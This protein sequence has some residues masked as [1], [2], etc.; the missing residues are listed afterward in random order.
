MAKRTL[1]DLIQVSLIDTKSNM[2]YFSYFLLRMR[3]VET[4][5]IETMGV[6]T[7]PTHITLYYNPEFVS[8]LSY[9]DF[10]YVLMHEILHITNFHQEREDKTLSHEI[11]NIAMDLAVNSILGIANAPK[12]VIC[13]GKG[14]F[15]DFP[16]NKSMEEY[17]ELLKKKASELKNKNGS[18]NGLEDESLKSHDNY[19]GH[20][21]RRKTGSKMSDE[22]KKMAEENVKN[23]MKKAYEYAKSKGDIPGWLEETILAQISKKINWK[24]YLRNWVGEVIQMGVEPSRRI[25]NKRYRQWHGIIPGLK[26]IYINPILIA[27]DTSGSMSQESLGRFIGEINNIQYPKTIIQCDAEITDVSVIPNKKLKE[28]KMKGRGGTDFRP[29]FKYA[30]EI[31]A[32]AL[33]FFTDLMGDFPEK[34]PKLKTLWITEEKEATAPFGEVVRML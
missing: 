15:K 29:V 1:S 10:K 32:K 22:E 23:Q 25:R 3:R 7:F 18:G 26:K 5:D 33:I 13:P 34:P 4:K 14:L 28:L 17:L 8:S 20:E 27:I 12:G 11:N 6:V 16:E 21:L 31:K 30:E 2:S 24:K 9:N 19:D